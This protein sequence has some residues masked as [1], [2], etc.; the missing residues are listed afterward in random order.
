MLSENLPDADNL[1]L[2]RSWHA[3]SKILGTKGLP[4]KNR[5]NA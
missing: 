1:D 2:R 5:G 4:Q 3:K